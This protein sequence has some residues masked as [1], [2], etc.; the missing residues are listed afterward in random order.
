MALV[1]SQGPDLILLSPPSACNYIRYFG[2]RSVEAIAQEKQLKKIPQPPAGP[3]R[4]EE[5]AR[6]P[7]SITNTPCSPCRMHPGLSNNAGYMMPQVQIPVIPPFPMQSP[8]MNMPTSPLQGAALDNK[9][10]VPG[11]ISKRNATDPF[12]GYNNNYIVDPLEPQMIHS[13]C[14]SPC[15][16]TAWNDTPQKVQLNR[17]LL[18]NEPIFEANELSYEVHNT[19]IMLKEEP[20]SPVR[21]AARHV[22]SVPCTPLRT[23]HTD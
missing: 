4:L 10:M 18:E 14:V 20:T 21:R 8:N 16:R 13:P 22:Q 12:Q 2:Q 3:P 17:S 9:L 19:F 7:V 15:N 5:G 23:N 6:S 1:A 11:L